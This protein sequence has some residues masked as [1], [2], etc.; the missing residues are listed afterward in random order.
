MMHN[1]STFTTTAIVAVLAAVGTTVA[2]GAEPAK[3]PKKVFPYVRSE[4]GPGFVP[5][6]AK[7]QRPRATFF[8]AT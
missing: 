1:R 7:C 6:L 3:S 8:V 5:L 2:C 4:D